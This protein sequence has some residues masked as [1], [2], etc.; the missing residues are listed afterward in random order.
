[1]PLKQFIHEVLRRSRTNFITLQTALCYVEV[2]AAKLP[3][4]VQ[5]EAECMVLRASVDSDDDVPPLPSP[6]LC[7]RRTFLAS[8]LLASKFLQDRSYSNKAWA[9]LTGLAAREVG[10]CE[11]ALFASLNWRLWVGKGAEAA[12]AIEGLDMVPVI[13]IDAPFQPDDEKTQPTLLRKCASEASLASVYATAPV[14]TRV[15]RPLR[16]KACALGAVEETVNAGPSNWAD[17]CIPLPPSPTGTDLQS[18]SASQPDAYADYASLSS[19]SPDSLSLSSGSSS[20]Y[21]EVGTPP[22]DMCSS[23]HGHGTSS[24]MPPY[25]VN[26]DNVKLAVNSLPYLSFGTPVSQSDIVG[27][28]SWS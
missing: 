15:I 4:L 21:S 17:V 28:T 27:G 24:V 14:P 1:M 20:A 12:Q 19:L 9:K 11:R 23:L 7:P 26:A 2:I 13:A 18:L 16:T 25:G 5:E 3:A 10:R 6:L 8:I 22:D